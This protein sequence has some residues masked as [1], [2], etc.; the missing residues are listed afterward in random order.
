[1]KKSFTL[2]LKI[3]RHLPHEKHVFLSLEE[4]REVAITFKC[5]QVVRFELKVFK[6]LNQ[7]TVVLKTVQG[8]SHLAFNPYIQFLLL[9]GILNTLL[10]NQ[11]FS[12][13]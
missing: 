7:T 3:C 13:F 5:F 2:L 9:K 10:L 1:M 11:P 6:L 12:D 4:L 8:P